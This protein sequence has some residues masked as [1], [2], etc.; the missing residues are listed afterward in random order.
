ME[1]P[2][3][4]NPATGPAE[5]PVDGLHQPPSP[6]RPLE[7]SSRRKR[8]RAPG[9]WGK[10]PRHALS[11]HLPHGS[12]EHPPTARLHPEAGMACPTPAAAYRVVSRPGSAPHH[13][14]VTLTTGSH[15]CLK[16]GTPDLS[17]LR[18]PAL[19]S[20]PRLAPSTPSTLQPQ[21][22]PTA[23]VCCQIFRPETCCK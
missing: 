5:L 8:L 16:H 7:D 22:L 20:P 14:P 15:A 9:N 18:P 12:H 10:A 11:K 3:A 21:P 1:R 23:L 6:K 2:H 4:G 19:A 13:S 17:L